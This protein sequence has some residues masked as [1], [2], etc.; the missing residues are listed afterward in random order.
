MSVETKTVTFEDVQEAIN[1]V[2]C[3]N[4]GGCGIAALA[5]ARWIKKNNPNWMTY[6]SSW[7]IMTLSPSS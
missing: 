1:Q 7:V 3:I 6:L 2:P 4:R 5:M